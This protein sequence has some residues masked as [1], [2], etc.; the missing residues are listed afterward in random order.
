MDSDFNPP[1]PVYIPPEFRSPSK[2]VNRTPKFAELEVSD[3]QTIVKF[4]SKTSKTDISA[5]SFFDGLSDAN[6]FCAMNSYM[7]VSPTKMGRVNVDEFSRGDH[8]PG[9]PD[10][11]APTP[12]GTPASAASTVEEESPQAPSTSGS[13]T[14]TGSSEE[15]GIRTWTPEEGS[16]RAKKAAKR[17]LEQELSP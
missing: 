14:S 7:W 1:S 8:L 5:E 15:H 11:P 6:K 12:V 16:K 13:S 17:E 9:K 10:S 4:L 3:Q 2:Q